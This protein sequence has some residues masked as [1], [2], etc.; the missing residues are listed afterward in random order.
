M[1]TS[2]QGLTLLELMVAVSV[3]AVLAGMAA[4]S[5]REFSSNT[6][7]TATHND[8]ITSL[9]LARSEALRRGVPVTVCAS[10]NAVACGL[11]TDWVSGWIVF[12]NPGTAGVIES[13][14]D[15]VQKWNSPVGNIRL[16]A[17]RAFLQYQPTG[18]VT[19][20]GTFDVSYQNCGGLHRRHVQVAASGALATQLQSCP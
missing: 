11:A 14:D 19:A 10:A 13:G 9:N 3:L 20:A 17:S 4:P 18:V 15:V 6:R 2:Q 7:V 12:Q 8:L 5:F 1:R 16:A